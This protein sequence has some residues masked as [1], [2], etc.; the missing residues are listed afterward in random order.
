VRPRLFLSDLHL[1]PE[2]AA[3]AAAFR[4]FCAGPARQAE[5]VYILGD[6]FDWWIGDDQ[7]RDRFFGDMA[8][9]IRGITDAGVPVYFALGNRDFLLGPRFASATGATLLPD[10]HLV[11][12]ASGA[13]LVSHGDEL[14][15]GDVDY[16]N[17]RKRVRDPG[18]QRRLLG[19]PLFV[20]KLIARWLRRK[21]RNATAL[22]AESIM[23]VDAQAVEAAFREF[24]VTRMIH[25]HTHRPAT[26]ALEVDGVARER[27]VLGDWHGGGEYVE[28][29]AAGAHR[30]RIAA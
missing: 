8:A 25:G 24:E 3:E 7:L 19:L 22:K 21:S 28:L 5:A 1:A 14:C 15:L 20:R 27:I 26:H 29:D 6:L 9:C 10:R 17:Y 16:Q 2:R 12:T 30:R 4:A 11:A 23:D 13:V 18:T